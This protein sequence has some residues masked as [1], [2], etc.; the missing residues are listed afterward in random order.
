MLEVAFRRHGEVIFEHYLAQVHALGAE[1]P[2]AGLL[3]RIT[4]ELARL[5][6]QS[7]DRSLHRQD[8]PYRRALTGI[9]ARLDA[10]ALSFGLKLQHRMAVGAGEAYASAEAFAADLDVIDASLR[11]G[12]R[13]L[14]ADGRLRRVRKGLTALGFS[15]PAVAPGPKSDVHDAGVPQ[16]LRGEGAVP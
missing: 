16:R 11:A 2:L 3:A 1:L 13:A 7:P 8:E 14:L 5:A 12:G 9:Y 4:P 6:E 15:L 10:T